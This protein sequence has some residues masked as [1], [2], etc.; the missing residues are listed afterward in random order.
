MLNVIN[1]AS[2]KKIQSLKTDSSDD[3]KK[4]YQNARNALLKWRAVPSS[5]KKRIVLR[6]GELVDKN[7]ERLAQLLTDEMGKPI[8]QSRGEI[9]SVSKRLEFFTKGLNAI[10]WPVKMPEST[11]Y[12]WARIPLK[13]GALTSLEFCELM[14]REAGVACSPGTG[15]GDYGEGYVRFALVGAPFP[16]CPRRRRNCIL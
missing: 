8:E 14:L 9:E 2:G 13:Y 10:G 6:F 12:L 4:K 11:F 1:P 5:E 7:S 15:F 3:I 16:L